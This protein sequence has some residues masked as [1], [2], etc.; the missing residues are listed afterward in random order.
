[1]G[2]ESKRL[3]VLFP[4]KGYVAGPL[5]YYANFKYGA[6]GYESIK[7]NYDGCFQGDL[8]FDAVFE[9]MN[10][11]VLEQIRD[12]NFLE[13]DNIVFVSKS[14]GTAVA[15]WLADKLNINTIRHIFDPDK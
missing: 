14:L 12:V 11:H 10:N 9:N 5:L 2:K 6:D 4:G 1:M 15:G 13:Y 8:S 3:L 7:I